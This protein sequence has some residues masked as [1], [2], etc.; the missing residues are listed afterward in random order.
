MTQKGNLSSATDISK[1][2]SSF[3]Y[4]TKN[5]LITATDP[6][7]N[8]FNY[9]YDTKHNISTATSAQNVKY[10]FTYDSSGNPLTS[11][12]GDSTLFIQSSANYTPSGNYLS[13]LTDPSG[14]TVTNNWNET[15]GLLNS[16]T[17]SKNTIT[18]YTYE[19]NTNRLSSVAKAVSGQQITNGYTYE[20]DRIKS[21]TQNGFNYNFG[22][23]SLGNKTNVSVG[24]QNLITNSFENRTGKLLQSTYGNGQTVSQDYDSSDRVTASKYNGIT[25]D[26]YAYDN[27]GNLGYKQDLVNA[28]NYRYLYD[29]ANRLT[30]V[31]NSTGNSQSYAYDQSNLG[32]ITE[33][34]N[35]STHTTS[36]AYDKDNRPTI[37]TIND[38]EN[39]YAD[40]GFELGTNTVSYASGVSNAVIVGPGFDPGKNP[41]TGSKC[42][43][44][45]GASND[46]Y[47]YL[48]SNTPVVPG[49]T[50]K[51]SF[52]HMEATSGQFTGGSSFIRLNDGSHVPLDMS[53]TS[54]KA[55][56]NAE[57]TWT[58][59]AGITSIQL[60]FGFRTNYNYSW[61]GVDDVTI[62]DINSPVV[63]TPST[64]TQSYDALGRVTTKAINTGTATYNSIYGY[65]PGVNGSTTTKVG[66]ISNSG[67]GINYT[68][69]A[70]GNIETIYPKRT[71]HQVLLR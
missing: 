24:T 37:T 15:K 55:W 60:R 28:D 58:C 50:Y 8:N 12:V 57:T 33:K 66:S 68:Y 9:T 46:D 29:F 43:W 22:Y 21:I 40:G 3:A 16:I 70:N 30:K 4:N 36:Y 53:L 6:K 51:I 65:L 25:R 41:R 54:D 63:N 5:D 31:T 67:V 47:A 59:P 44:M 27:N 2:N 32:S 18:N 42:L 20:N 49:K 10:S 39:L 52:Y 23:D 34:V 1:Q 26:T 62:T 56:R 38:S 17:D 35:G 45:D 48:S 14:N 13:S 64:I 71:S 11:K 69:D 61:M 19:A 7:R